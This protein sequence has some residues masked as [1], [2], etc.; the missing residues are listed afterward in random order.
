MG[1]VKIHDQ[2]LSSS[3]LEEDLV[4][5]WVW[6]CLLVQCDRNGNVYGTRMALA[7]RANVTLEE[8]DQALD[9]LM[10]PDKN[11]TSPEEDGRRIT[12]VGP[13]N[14]H[15]VV[16]K[17]RR[18]KRARAGN[19]GNADVTK[20]NPIAEAEAEAE[21]ETSQ[22]GEKLVDDS[23]A[24]G[25]RSWNCTAEAT[26]LPKAPNKTKRREAVHRSRLKKYG[27]SAIIQ[28]LDAPRHSAFLRGEKGRE[29]WRGATYDW[30]MKLEN[31]IK[32]LEGNYYD[33][34]YQPPQDDEEKWIVDTYRES[35]LH[36]HGNHSRW[37]EYLAAA[38]DYDPRAA[39][40]FKEWL[41]GGSDD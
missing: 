18:R 27:F 12:E 38:A 21:A 15:C 19:A 39:P 17:H 24:E 5:R 2:I 25:L 22:G 35:C 31:F 14:F 13:N 26:G 29:T 41:K 20:S 10:E 33:K 3:I 16:E 36:E 40:S 7:R 32:V 8:F 6:I 4:V 9:V 37:V 30:L 1:F 11:S 28:V 34:G 23:L